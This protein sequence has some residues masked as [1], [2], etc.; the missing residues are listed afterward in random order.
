VNRVVA[1]TLALALSGCIADLDPASYVSDARPLAARVSIASDP[2]RAQPLPGETFTLRWLIASPGDRPA[3]AW[4]FVACPAVATSIGET[5]C[6]GDAVGFSLQEEPIDA[7]PEIEVTVPADTEVDRVLVLGVLCAGGSPV[8]DLDAAEVGCTEPSGETL[9]QVIVRLAEDAASANQH[10]TVPDDAVRLAGEVWSATAADVP[11]DDCA[12]APVPQASVAAGAVTIAF[13]LP[14]AARETYA[15]ERGEAREELAIAQAATAKSFPRL[16]SV[17]DDIDPEA[18]VDFTPEPVDP[19]PPGGARVKFF[20]VVRD[21]RGG[22]TFTERA[23][24]LVP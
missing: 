21:D 3:L 2:E 7:E 8:V 13:V 20:F 5:F 18:N 17:V 6:V 11:S 16:L 10:P 14:D 22:V 24:C 12:S 15:T 19:P 4:G 1:T 9:V 23:L